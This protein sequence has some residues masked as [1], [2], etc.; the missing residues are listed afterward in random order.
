M[1]YN[2]IIF[3]M[4]DIFFDATPWRRALTA[5]LQGVG[6]KI[7][8]TELCR[9]W[10]AK[11]ADVYVGRSE[12]WSTLGRFLEELGLTPTQADQALTFARDKA[13]QV[14]QPTLFEGV[15]ETLGALKQHGIKLAVLSDTESRESKVRS[16]LAD[17]GIEQYFDAVITSN[18]I[19]HA[20]PEPESYQAALDALEVSADQTIF[21]GHDE[22][23]LRG[24]MRCGLCT[25]AFNGNVGIPCDH[26]FGQFGEL[27]EL[28]AGSAS[29][30]PE[31][32]VL[33]EEDET[34]LGHT[35]VKLGKMSTVYVFGQIGPLVLGVLLLPVF[36]RYLVP[37]Q[38]GIVS[39]S[40]RL[41]MVLSVLVHLEL[42]SAL[43]I[44]YFRTEPSLRAELVRTILLGQAMLAVVI[45]TVLSVAGIWLAERLLPNLPL[46]REYVFALWL[47]I[48]WSPLYSSF[49]YLA[50]HLM[51]LQERAGKAVL[52]TASV[53][54]LQ[55]ALGVFV[56]VVLGWQGFGRQS[57]ICSA[58]VIVGC[59]S[60]CFLWRRG[61]GNFDFATFRRL[62]AIGVTFVPH[63]LS[64]L[65]AVAVNVWL[66]NRLVSP[67]ALA[68]Y[69]IALMFPKLITLTIT[70]I[71]NAAYPTLARLMS[72]G[73]DEAKRKQ[74]RLYT[75]L[76]MGVA[77]LT[78]GVWLFGP[79][80]IRLLTTPEYHDATRV[81]PILALASLFLGLYL[82]VSQ[83]AFYFGGGLW[84]SA[85][86]L[87][88][89]VVATMFSLLL[90]PRFGQYGA[91]W[92]MVSCYATRCLVAVVASRHLY[93][94][95]WQISSILRIIGCTGML[96]LAG[97]WASESLAVGWAIAVNFLLLLSM[98]AVLWLVGVITTGEFQRGADL[99]RN[100]LVGFGVKSG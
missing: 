80:A 18:D 12:Y 73:S 95:P 3:D 74:S 66:L 38:L 53:F 33:V 40:L 68:V 25:V 78:L 67:A 11:L 97:L 37:E 31:D 17:L 55:I 100:N 44:R 57:M 16:R 63:A 70:S 93:R 94:L 69:S 23:E 39:L 91:A 6:V 86:S 64:G 96:A 7:G 21:V 99:L 60:F 85:G 51:A 76:I 92:A 61:Q 98:P 83:P 1:P 88:S 9:R 42:S 54:L 46:S 4:G 32:Q 36:T 27:L 26:N 82:V 65:L 41:S 72:D 28:A 81:V 87:A 49:V 77:S 52:I 62:L 58:T 89:I 14:E 30:P 24:A 5:H 15:A 71:G 48:V 75:M 47:M 43:K 2:A 10:E 29:L 34:S 20:K 79:A 22:D 35:V 59:S 90:I 56:V 45:C 19:G 50:A 13:G 84:L 8:Y